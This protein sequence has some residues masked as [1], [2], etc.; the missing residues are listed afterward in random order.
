MTNEAQKKKPGLF[1]RLFGGKSDATGAPTGAESDA[2]TSADTEPSGPVE[3]AA[4]DAP[5]A[6]PEEPAHAGIAAEA[7]PQFPPEPRQTWFQ[8][9][10]SGLTRTSSKLTEGI[11]GLFNKRKL[12]GATLEDLEDL[13]IQADLGVETSSKIIERIAKGRFEKGI[14]AD[15]VRDILAAEVE[16]VLGPSPRL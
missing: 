2:D 5:A 14:S 8:R 12:D 7:E 11:T 13:L 10:K 9:L 16:A 6:P 1:G 15:E 3:A 4:G